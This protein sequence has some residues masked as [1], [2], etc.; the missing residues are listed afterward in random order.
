MDPGT[1]PESHLR[2][3]GIPGKIKRA[4]TEASGLTDH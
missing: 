4:K 3:P 2:N 1:T